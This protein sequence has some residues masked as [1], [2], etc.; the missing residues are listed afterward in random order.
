MAL[1]P[2][3][4]FRCSLTGTVFRVK[5]DVEE[6]LILRPSLMNEGLSWKRSRFACLILSA[7]VFHV[8]ACAPRP[9][10]SVTRGGELSASQ[11]LRTRTEQLWHARQERDCPAVFSFEDPSAP[12]PTDEAA[13]LS[14]CREDDPF[15]IRAYNIAAAE[16]DGDMGWV[17]IETTTEFAKSPEPQVTQVETWEK[18]HTVKGQWYPLQHDEQMN[19]PEAPSLRNTAEEKRLRSRFAEA[20]DAMHA[21]DWARLY[22]L[23]DPR[24]RENITEQSF[25]KAAG[26]LQYLSYELHWIEVT[27]ERGRV[28]VSYEHKVTDPN[29]TKMAPRTIAVIDYWVLREGTWFRDLKRP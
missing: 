10:L 6:N 4:F 2:W 23:V 18:W 1:P 22:Q 17:R 15:R 14:W 24:D 12:Q 19:Y 20:W 27:G 13:F 28:R 8:L 29:L 5:F 21:G 9:P 11:A 3:R 7:A 26:T 16:T 25:V